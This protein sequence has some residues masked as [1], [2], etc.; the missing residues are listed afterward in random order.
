MDHGGAWYLRLRAARGRCAASSADGA[1]EVV[2]H[3]HVVEAVGDA[4]AARARRASRSLDLARALG[5]PLA[6]PA[7]ELGERRRVTKIVTALGAVSWTRERAL[8][9]ELE[10]AARALAWIRSISERSVP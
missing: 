6:Q 7:L 4:R 3:D 1:V 10:H 2:V 9:L 8:G 5:R